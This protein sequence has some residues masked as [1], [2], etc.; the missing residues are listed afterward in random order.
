VWRSQFPA[1]DSKE[2]PALYRALRR[3]GCGKG[4]VR[5]PKIPRLPRHIR[6]AVR[7]NPALGTRDA[8]YGTTSVMATGWARPQGSRKI[9]WAAGCQ[10]SPASE[11]PRLFALRTKTCDREP[12]RIW[13]RFIEEHTPDVVEEICAAGQ[14][15]GSVRNGRGFGADRR[16]RARPNDCVTRLEA[17]A[18][19]GK[20][21]GFQSRFAL[22]YGRPAKKGSPTA[23]VLR[24]FL[25][26]WLLSGTRPKRSQAGGNRGKR[27]P[28]D[29]IFRGTLP[30]L[31]AGPDPDLVIPTSG[32]QHLSVFTAV[33]KAPTRRMWSP[34]AN[35]PRAVFRGL[36]DFLFRGMRGFF[37]KLAP[38]AVTALTGV[39]T[40]RACLRFGVSWCFVW[41]FH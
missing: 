10:G 36:L 29:A 19:T 22:G 21:G 28:S 12:G 23:R 2:K 39:A 6:G 8:G 5:V 16:G 3:L 35:W 37:N 15:A 33:A 32:E 14:P 24:R 26:F 40:L 27:S 30:P 41:C 13:P 38:I 4:P 1:P 25:F 7:R 31:R 20:N 17:T 11:C 18:S 34:S 9:G